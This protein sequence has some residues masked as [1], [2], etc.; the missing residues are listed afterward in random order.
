MRNTSHYTFPIFISSLDYNLKDLRA[1]LSRYLFELGYKPILSNSDGFPDYCPKFK[2][3]ESCLPVLQNSFVVIIIIDGKYG[4]KFGWPNFKDIIN[5]REVS[6]THGEY[7]FAHSLKIRMLVFIRKE[8]MAFYRMYREA[9]RKENKENNL[10]S[11][12]ELLLPKHV[13]IDTLEFIE[14][15]KTKMP[16]P[17][18]KEF[19]DIT[20]VKKEIQLKMVNELAEIFMI[21]NKH[22]EA[23]INAFE[24]T[25]ESI[26][27]EKREEILQK[28]NT[29]RGCAK[30]KENLIQKKI[31]LEKIKRTKNTQGIDNKDKENE[32]K[33]L[34]EKISQM[35]DQISNYENRYEGFFIFRDGKVQIHKSYLPNVFSSSFPGISIEDSYLDTFSSYTIDNVCNK[36]GKKEVKLNGTPLTASSNNFHFCPL[37]N[38]SYCEKCW[39][40]NQKINCPNCTF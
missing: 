36:C 9:K 22:I 3:W 21:Q 40:I 20:F 26:A 29:T 33:L 32:I 11:Q 4:T 15:V 28:L 18:I 1:E 39:P 7:I 25:M 16:I 35:E 19:D 13:D 24:E 12:L 30:V 17:W 8:V 37:C 34:N 23:I 6:P 2:P 5:S 31:E 27:P 10:R 14:E 38:K